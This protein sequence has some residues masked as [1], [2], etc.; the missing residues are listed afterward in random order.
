MPPT[1][2]PWEIRMPKFC[3]EWPVVDHE[4]TLIYSDICSNSACL[5]MKASREPPGLTQELNNKPE[6][7]ADTENECDL[8]KDLKHRFLSFKKHKYMWAIKDSCQ[9]VI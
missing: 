9:K 3:F 6:R 4:L 8:F 2:W 1:D 7:L 5:T